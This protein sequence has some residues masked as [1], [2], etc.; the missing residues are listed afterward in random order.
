[1]ANERRGTDAHDG[2]SFMSQMKLSYMIQSWKMP[3]KDMSPGLPGRPRAG[4]RCPMNMPEHLKC[5][6]G[7][8]E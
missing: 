3:L 8:P 6:D 5:S 7:E 1:M 4:R 2:R